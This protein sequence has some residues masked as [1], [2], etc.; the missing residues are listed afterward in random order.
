MS[1]NNAI[2]LEFDEVSQNYYVVWQPIIMGMGATT[3]KALDDLR[4]AAH[5]CVD[6]FIDISFECDSNRKEC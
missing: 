5:C 2:K 6:T 1:P 3:R 4:E